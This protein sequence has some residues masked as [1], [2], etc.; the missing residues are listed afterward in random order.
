MLL[1]NIKSLLS[2][3]GLAIFCGRAIISKILRRIA[4]RHNAQAL[5]AGGKSEHYLRSWK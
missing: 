1:L 3:Y 5:G 4:A 2:C